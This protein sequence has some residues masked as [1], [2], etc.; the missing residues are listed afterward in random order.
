MVSRDVISSRIEAVEKGLSRLSAYR[1]VP[2]EDFMADEDMQDIVEYNL[3][4]VVNSLID[5]CEH[6][7][8]DEVGAYPESAYNAVAVLHDKG[9][10][11]KRDMSNIRK[12][13]GF[14][15]VIA[16]DYVGIDKRA[17]FAALSSVN[18]DIPKI[19]NKILKFIKF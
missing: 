14:R 18:E 13:I 4:Q 10:F 6:I 16:H 7:A 2:F 12:M 5:M 11:S 1:G 19:I 9:L 17:V 8:V 3:F 15:N